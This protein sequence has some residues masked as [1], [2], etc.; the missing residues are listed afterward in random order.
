MITTLLKY[1]Y[2]LTK[3]ITTTVRS[4]NHHGYKLSSIW[5][6]TFDHKYAS[7]ARILGVY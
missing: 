7:K 6:Q 1:D 3:F 4:C 2:I 5:L